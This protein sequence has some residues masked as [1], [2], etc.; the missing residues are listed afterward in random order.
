MAVGAAGLGLAYYFFGTSGSA[1]DTGRELD[2]KVRGAVA[3]VEGKV[4]MRRGQEE[5]QKVYNRVA[6]MLE[7][8]GYDGM[9]FPF[10]TV[11]KC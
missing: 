10:H 1:R 8:E 7:E 6:D 9:F 2:S 5:Y 11:G 4:G 3:A